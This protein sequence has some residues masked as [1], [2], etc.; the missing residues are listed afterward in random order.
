MI[1]QST[2]Q[3][4][5]ERMNAFDVINSLHPLKQ[6]GVNWVA[7]CPFHNEKSA[8]FK[9]SKT[10]NIFK[11]FGACSISG[12]TIEFVM[13][14]K[15]ILYPAAI[16]WLCDFYKITVE[17]ENYEPVKTYAKPI[18]KDGQIS[19]AWLHYFADRGISGATL[20]H[21][22]V[23]MANEWMPK[24][25]GNTDAICFNYFR[26]GELINIKYRAGYAVEKDFKLSKDAELI[27]YNLD[28]I[29]GK[30]TVIIVEGEI[31]ALSVYQ[32]GVTKMAI[33]SVPNGAANGKLELKYLT[34]CADAFKGVKNIV[35][36]SDNDDPGKLLRDELARRFGYDK[37]LRVTFPDGCKDAN[38]VLVKFGVEKVRQ[39]IADAEEFPIE[40]VFTIS[41]FEQDVLNYYNNGYPVGIKVGIPGF[42]EHLQLMLGQV[43]T[44]TGIPGSGKSEFCDFV[45]TSSAQ[46]H[47]WPWGVCSFENQPSSLHVTK[48]MEKYIGKSFA[49]RYD[50]SDRISPE[51]VPEALNFVSEHFYFININ[52]ITVTLE[53]ILEKAKELVLR[54]GIKGLL[55]DPWNYIEHKIG[56][57]QTETQYISDCLTTLKSF[58]AV[59]GIHIFLIA[60]PAKMAKISG[61]YEIPT[62]YSISGS[63]H[64][65]NKTDNGVCVNRNYDNN[66]VDV[67]I[68]KIRF[69]WLGKVGVA[70]FIYN[71]DTRQYEAISQADP[72][73][74]PNQEDELPPNPRSGMPQSYPRSSEDKRDQNNFNPSDWPSLKVSTNKQEK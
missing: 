51:Q 55:I 22:G 57:G 70:S 12:D 28:S 34:N 49:K 64:F 42:D 50:D 23:T 32:A 48:I 6:E 35:L 8:S 56:K 33:V 59:H 43:T 1:S 31:D 69:S 44:W 4:V 67:F 24:A 61:K 5:K 65:F 29:A 46:N 39:I 62:M 53:G 45:M 21:F 38:D 20:Q 2:I 37:C 3:A 54:R 66:T 11:C 17:Q 27:F 71:I 15:Q 18:L 41:D 63:A 9:V 16:E 26:S 74:P 47:N 72:P 30:D 25:K 58:A 13:K 7:C 10:K 40:G 52:K 19:A 14:F 60:H 73:D 68:Q 36:M